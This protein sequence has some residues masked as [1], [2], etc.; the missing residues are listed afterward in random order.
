MAYGV[1]KLSK[2]QFGR[3]A[4][5]G[6]AVA[7]DELWRGPA[8]M[9]EDMRT[10]VFSEEDI[11]QLDPLNRYYDAAYSA[12]LNM[13]SQPATFE[14]ILHIFEA[15][16]TADTPAQ[17]ASGGY[18]YVYELNKSDNAVKTYT[19]EGGDSS[20]VLEMEYGFVTQFV[21]SGRVDEAVMLD[22]ATWLGRQVTDTSFTAD[23]SPI[24]VE[25]ILFNQGNLYIDAS[26]GSI[27]TTSKAG[28]LTGFR[29]TVETG[30]RPVRAANGELYFY[31]VKNAGGTAQLELTL[32][33]DD[34]TAVAERAAMRS[35]SVRLVRLQFDGTTIADGS[36]FSG[37]ALRIDFEGI[38]MPESFR[39][40]SDEDGDNIVTGTLRHGRDSD[41]DDVGVQI[42]VNNSRSSLD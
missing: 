19:F 23:I 22:S 27:G 15:G 26:G 38:W 41:T 40:L 34:T 25:E 37:K 39:T 42:T 13:P 9:V 32:E 21:L 24:A 36:A 28:I 5:A 4:T 18:M 8:A 17:D 29:L 3:E 2:L 20:D 33:H 35:G 14:Q 6:T 1:R 30:W 10:R 12:Q 11:G 31:S 16:I 7:A